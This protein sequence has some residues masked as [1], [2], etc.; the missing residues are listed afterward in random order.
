MHSHNKQ[1]HTCTLVG[2]YAQT[3][4]RVPQKLT[5]VACCVGRGH[6]TAHSTRIGLLFQVLLLAAAAVM[7]GDFINWWR[8]K[9]F[10]GLLGKALQF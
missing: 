5:G 7:A 4:V 10:V 1:K 6:L 8:W 3:P 2:L 9:R